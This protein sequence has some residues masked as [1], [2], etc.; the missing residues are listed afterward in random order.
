M[1]GRAWGARGDAPCNQVL[2]LGVVARLSTLLKRIKQEQQES[3]RMMLQQQKD[4]GLRFKEAGGDVNG[5]FGFR[6]KRDPYASASRGNGG[7]I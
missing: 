5:E 2:Q 7:L 3:Y 1:R 6:V 4:M